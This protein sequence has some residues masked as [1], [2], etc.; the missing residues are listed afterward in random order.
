VVNFDL[1]NEPESYVHRIGRTARAGAFARRRSW[2]FCARLRRPSA[3]RFPSGKVMTGTTNHSPSVMRVASPRMAQGHRPRNSR[4]EVGV[5]A[6]AGDAVGVELKGQRS[7]IE[8]QCSTLSF[9]DSKSA[10][11]SS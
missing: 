2:N 4:R 1:P 3:W 5:P 10:V 7:R 8:F 6:K 9:C 11:E